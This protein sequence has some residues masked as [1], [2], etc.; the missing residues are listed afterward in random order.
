VTAGLLGHVVSRGRMRLRRWTLAVSAFADVDLDLR[1][2]ELDAPRTSATLLVAFGN[3]DVYVPEGVAVTVGGFGLFGHRRDWGQD[4]AR[5]DSPA[6]HVRAFS[7]FGTVDVWRVP[8]GMRGGYG[9]V[10]RQLQAGQ[11]QLPR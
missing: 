2:A 8:R 3:V 5:G 10:T 7:L 9:K 1:E 6:I 4:T 11:R